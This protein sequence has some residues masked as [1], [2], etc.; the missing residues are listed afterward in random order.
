MINPIYNF[1]LKA[2][3]TVFRNAIAK[4][5]YSADISERINHLIDSIN[6][7]VWQYTTRGLFECDKLIFTTQMAFQIQ[8]AKG[9]IQPKDLDFLLRFPITPNVTSPVDFLTNNSWGA[10]KS[11]TNMDDYR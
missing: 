10:V 4:A 1:S 6:F 7:A 9:A 5:V 11:L 8:L 3:S 2:F